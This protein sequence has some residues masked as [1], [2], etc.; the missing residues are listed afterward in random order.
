[1]LTPEGKN[2]FKISPENIKL[3][4]D[5]TKY[6]GFI[7]SD[8]SQTQWEGF[9][10]ADSRWTSTIVNPTYAVM[11]GPAVGSLNFTTLFSG[12]NYPGFAW[13]VVVWSGNQIIGGGRVSTGSGISFDEYDVTDSSVVTMLSSYNRSPVPIPSAAWLFGAGLIGF[14][15]ARRK[16][17]YF[18]LAESRGPLPFQLKQHVCCPLIVSLPMRLRRIQFRRYA[19]LYAHWMIQRDAVITFFAEC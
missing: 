7:V 16:L 5:F 17:F 3:S 8:P 6:E 10:L 4:D 15:G 13:D 11:E 2:T 19:S 9:I 18:R 14:I 12:N 1:L